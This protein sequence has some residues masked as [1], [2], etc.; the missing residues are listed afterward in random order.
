MR[1]GQLRNKVALQ[2]L[3][4]D[5][6]E[7]GQPVTTWTNVASVYAD[8]RHQTGLE[9]LKGD[10]V[11]SIV[12]ASIRIRHR[13]GVTAGMRVLHGTTVYDIEAVLPDVAKNAYVDLVCGVV[14][15]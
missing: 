6:D 7:I 14:N 1:A 2:Q 15:G 5:Q 10:A 4:E 8:I 11:A 9:S 13:E 12:K 3:T